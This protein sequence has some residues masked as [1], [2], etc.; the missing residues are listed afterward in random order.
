MPY[1]GAGIQRFNTADSLTVN[2]DAEVT[3]TVNPSGDTASGDAAAVGFTS[4]EGLILT[5]QGSTSDITVKNDADAT[6]FTV[7]TGTDDILFPDSAEIQMGA[8]ADLKISSD[9]TNGVLRANNG[10]IY[11]QSDTGIN[12]TKIGNAETMAIATPDGSVELYHD[13]TKRIETTSV[14]IGVDQ[15]F[16]L[17]DTDTGLALGANGSDIL[18]IYTGNSERARVDA[19]GNLLVGVT[20]SGLSANTG[21]QAAGP[22]ESNHSLRAESN[23]IAVNVGND[24]GSGVVG[25]ATTHALNVFSNNTT[26]LQ[27]DTEGVLG[28][29]NGRNSVGI[30]SGKTSVS[31]AD[32]ASVNIFVSGSHTAGRGILAIYE[33]SNGG[34][35]VASAGYNG[36]SIL[37]EQTASGDFVSGDT[38]GK[39][40]IVNSLHGLS[41]KNRIGA[42]KSFFLTWMGAGGT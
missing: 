30:L 5:G 8:G 34:G 19:N 31:L 16:G 2:G 38:D 21:V 18:Q 36:V 4:T 10:R 3:G 42:T 17:S 37:H 22:I 25:T 33:S 6:V 29:F 24:G 15:L 9:G 7:P 13:N 1:I 20:S 11:L 27:L 14:G 39:L 35:C 28:I 26:R 23:S 12:L 41:F 40:C 32:D